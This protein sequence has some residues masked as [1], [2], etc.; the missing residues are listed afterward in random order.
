MFNQAISYLKQ[1]GCDNLYQTL[2]N[3]EE[4]FIMHE[5]I[6][7]TANSFSYRD[8]IIDWNP[9]KGLYTTFTILSPTVL[10]NHEFDHAV[11]WL[12]SPND[13]SEKIRIL[14]DNDID[15]DYHTKEDKRV[16]NGSEKETAK[17]LGELDESTGITRLDHG[18]FPVKTV[19]P[20]SNQTD[21]ELPG[22]TIYH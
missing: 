3:S 22:V 17:K 8:G 20:I 2:E 10:L 14:P 9:T 1:Y 12:K 16:I 21:D 15:A 18:G 19:S 6:G 4:I 11:E 13:F 7:N 5:A